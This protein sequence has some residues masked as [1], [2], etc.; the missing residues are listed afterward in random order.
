MTINVTTPPFA[1]LNIED[2]NGI[3]QALS[4]TPSVYYI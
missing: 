1:D 3:D 2:I 4:D